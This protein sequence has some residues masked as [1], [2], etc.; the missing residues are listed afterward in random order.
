MPICTFAEIGGQPFIFIDTP[1]F[2]FAKSPP[3]QVKD[4]IHSTVGEFTRVLGGIH[5]ILYVQS[6]VE[7]RFSTGMRESIE[8]L[9]KLARD[10]IRPNITFITTQWDRVVNKDLGKRRMQ[11]SE[12]K[13]EQWGDF[14]VGE[15]NGARYFKHLGVD[16]DD[17]TVD[18]IQD[19]KVALTNG[20]MSYYRSREV[21]S[22]A[23]PFSEWTTGEKVGFIVFKGITNGAKLVVA[24]IVVAVFAIGI[25]GGLP[26]EVGGSFSIST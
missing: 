10:S 17:A 4:A 18:E 22:L 5:G 2:G 25:A 26:V 9:N 14:R 20:V 12:M 1:G 13:I 6:I 16:C 8:F 7:N 3:A 23:M 15:P 11:E 21:G 24:G 19:A